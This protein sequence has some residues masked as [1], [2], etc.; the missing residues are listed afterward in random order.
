MITLTT[1]GLEP[2]SGFGASATDAAGAEARA[3]EAGGVSKDFTFGAHLA[4]SLVGVV[5]EDAEEEPASDT[6]TQV[7]PASPA[8]P[9]MWLLPRGKSHG[10]SEEE[11]PPSQARAQS[12]AGG[13][14]AS[15]QLPSFVGTR[16]HGSDGLPREAAVQENAVFEPASFAGR[17]PEVQPGLP[18]VLEKGAASEGGGHTDPVM[19]RSTADSPMQEL[20]A[21]E[22]PTL[23]VPTN[24]VESHAASGAERSTEKR[25]AHSGSH[26][27][28]RVERS[29]QDGAD[30]EL[31][32]KERPAMEDPTTD[33][34]MAPRSD[35]DRR[36]K[37]PTGVEKYVEQRADPKEPAPDDAP[38]GNA[39]HSVEARAPHS[40]GAPSRQAAPG[41]R[42]DAPMQGRDGG[43]APTLQ[44][45]HAP[46]ADERRHGERE[47][48]QP[49][50]ARVQHTPAD[51]LAELARPF[52]EPQVR[53]VS[54]HEPA[55][56]SVES[57]PRLVTLSA[58]VQQSPVAGGDFALAPAPPETRGPLPRETAESIVHSLRLQY[59][60]GGGEAVVHIKPEHLG[61]VSVSLRVENG[62]VSAFVNAE[63]PAVAEWLKAN[64][65]L[66][67]DG[68]ASSGLHL[69]R[70]AVRREGEPADDGRRGW[71]PPDERAR[72]RR[73]LQPESTFE[74]TV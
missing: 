25:P 41:D 11:R 16:A 43:P 8:E 61:P 34:P 37:L 31:R 18:P 74:I 27:E 47:D 42:L 62:A 39:V 22:R 46:L 4:E 7:V 55:S 54:A 26:A 69:E 20:P 3:E 52:A 45:Q 24:V 53:Q 58:P 2:G 14:A 12:G 38:A 33:P 67:R 57:A 51:P 56:A 66:L 23:R 19:D 29:I 72:R 13:Q 15:G 70:F 60:R 36:V 71:R 64:E 44:R 50:E 35:G 59:Q 5:D 30:D 9:P 68:L 49:H 63:N 17:G 65:H 10:N 1:W 73:A 32:A 6:P 28:G 48:R 21:V 40:E